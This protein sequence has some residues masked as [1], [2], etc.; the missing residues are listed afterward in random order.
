MVPCDFTS[1]RRV[2]SELTISSQWVVELSADSAMLTHHYKCLN[3]DQPALRYLYAVKILHSEW[4]IIFLSYTVNQSLN[5]NG[6][7]ML[8]LRQ[9]IEGLI[10]LC[11]ELY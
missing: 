5:K 4:F 9:S 10:F 3:M 7:H 11:E 6:N 8:F 2:S 1:L